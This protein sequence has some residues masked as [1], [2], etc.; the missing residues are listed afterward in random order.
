MPYHTIELFQLISLPVDRFGLFDFI[1]TFP[2]VPI[3]TISSHFASYAR[4]SPFD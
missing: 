1:G 4:E 3:G 2:G